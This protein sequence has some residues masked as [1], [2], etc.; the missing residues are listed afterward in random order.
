MIQ[1]TKLGLAA[2]LAGGLVGATSNAAELGMTAPELDVAKFV[3]GKPV[4]LAK[5]RGSEVYVVEFW[6]TWCG[7]CRTSIPHLSELQAKFKNK[8]VTIIGISDETEAKVNP[9]VKEMGNK[10]DYVVAVDND[11]S[12]FGNY[13]TAFKQGGIPTAFIVDKAGK[14][15]WFGHPM[16]DLERVLGQVVDGKFD[17]ATYKTEQ[18]KAEKQQMA[19]GQYLDATVKGEPS[20]KVKLAGFDFVEDCENA[21]MLNQFSWTVLTHPQVKFRDLSLAT[22]AAKKAYD[23]TKGNDPSVTDTYARALYDSGEKAEAIK[24]QK[25]AVSKETNSQTKSQ[26]EAALKRYQSGR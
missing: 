13:M 3:K 8:G 24:Y 2:L 26:L 19:M 5:G 6:A 9:F 1:I 14:I 15:V 25:E 10:M 23:L 16:G 17:L 12:T 21:P 20:D 4:S 7:P 18:A 11:R 22:K